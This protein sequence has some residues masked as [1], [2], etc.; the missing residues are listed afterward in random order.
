MTGI[1]VGVAPQATVSEGLL[2]GK[3]PVLESDLPESASI[4]RKY[5]DAQDW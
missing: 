3:L 4:A 2:C 5:A 1:V